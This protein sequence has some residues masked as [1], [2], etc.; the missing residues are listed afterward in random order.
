MVTGLQSKSESKYVHHGTIVRNHHV[1]PATPSEEEMC[2][3]ALR[4]SMGCATHPQE[5]VVSLLTVLERPFVHSSV[6]GALHMA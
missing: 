1:M 3:I 6:Q 4:Q 2:Q 5:P